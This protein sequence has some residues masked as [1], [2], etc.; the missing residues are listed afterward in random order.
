M[1]SAISSLYQPLISRDVDSIPQAVRQ[2]R[3]QHSSIELLEAVT[4]FAVLA[5]SPSQHSRHA[6]LACLAAHSLRNEPGL[7]IDELITACAIY[8]AQSRPPWS[9]PPITDPPDLDPSESP[10]RRTLSE[11]IIS[12][13]RLKAERWLAANLQDPKLG[14]ELLEIAADDLADQGH[15]L[16]LT[17]AAVR[18]SRIMGE[19]GMFATLRLATAEWTAYREPVPELQAPKMAPRA[20][21]A[22]LIDRL[23]AMAG[24]TISF[25]AIELYDAALEAVK[26]G[27]SDSVEARVRAHLELTHSDN[28]GSITR[29]EEIELI[30]PVYALGRDYA[31][32]L[33]ATAISHRMTSRF[34]DLPCDQI[35]RASLYNLK[36]G[37]SFEDWSFA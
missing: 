33:L 15:K 20:L 21:A 3:R 19:K 35:V 27:A 2:F 10:D 30:P 23:T 26:L 5:F 11:A 12:G 7:E 24:D 34:P 13:D 17:A 37:P 8:T 29:V 6:V 31:Q 9:E 1:A 36:H 25:H 32:Y 22:I 14:R 4:R 28:D 18:L 16:I